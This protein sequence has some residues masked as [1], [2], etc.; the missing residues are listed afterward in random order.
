MAMSMFS[1]NMVGLIRLDAMRN[2]QGGF[3]RM[4]V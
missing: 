1:S 3:E 4:P 2:A